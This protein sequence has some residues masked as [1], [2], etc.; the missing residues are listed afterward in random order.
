MAWSDTWIRDRTRELVRTYADEER[1]TLADVLI[2]VQRVCADY[3]LHFRAHTTTTTAGNR[4]YTIPHLVDAVRV[5]YDGQPIPQSY[6]DN[7]NTYYL[8]QNT[9]IL[10]FSP[11]SGRTLV[12]EGYYTPSTVSEVGV[13]PEAVWMD[14]VAHLVASSVLARYG[15]QQAVSRATI[16]ESTGR[17]MLADL[18]KHYLQPYAPITDPT[19]W[20]SD[21]IKTRAKDWLRVLRLSGMVSDSEVESA[22]RETLLKARAVPVSQTITTI[23]GQ[24]VYPLERVAYVQRVVYDGEE[25]F[26]VERGSPLRGWYVDGAYLVL[27][28]EPDAGKRLVIEG[29]GVPQN[30]SDIRL[31]PAEYYMDGIAHYVCYK[32][33]STQ[34]DKDAMAMAAVHQQAYNEM[35][36]TLHTISAQSQLHRSSR[37]SVP[38]RYSLL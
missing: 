36:Q 14:A 17:A 20:S 5:L 19:R 15:D 18:V 29:Y 22:I 16:Y 31:Q 21:Y 10:N 35:V 7:T 38:K 9:L 33:L 27:S 4:V 24:P 34:P 3:R 13:E 30:L 26:R 1:A 28:F 37:K 23:G 11:P 6:R 8:R 2:T 25:L 12:V 32:I